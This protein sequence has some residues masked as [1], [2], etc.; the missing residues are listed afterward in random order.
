MC[1][2]ATVGK[3]ITSAVEKR[4]PQMPN[5]SPQCQCDRSFK[6]VTVAQ[7]IFTGTN[8][9]QEVSLMFVDVM[10]EQEEQEKQRSL[11]GEVR[12]CV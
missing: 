5:P 11:E 4:L 8:T 7:T 1:G 12:R 6:R 3:W 10:K 9:E 2:R